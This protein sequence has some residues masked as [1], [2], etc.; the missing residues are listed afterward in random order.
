VS[1]ARNLDDQPERGSSTAVPPRGGK[2]KNGSRPSRPPARGGN[3]RGGSGPRKPGSGGRQARQAAQ[4]RNRMYA[5]VAVGAAVVVI[6]VVVAIGVSGSSSGAP[7]RPATA[8]E[9]QQV[10]SIPVSTLVAGNQKIQPST[11]ATHAAGG[12]LTSNGKPELLFIGAEFCPVCATERWPMTIALMKFGTFNNLQVTSSAKAD[13]DI[14]TWSYYGSTYSSPYL[15]FNPK[16]LYTNQPSGNYYKPLDTLTKAEQANW[17]AN[18]GSNESFPFINFGGQAVLES[19]QFNPATLQ[20]KSFQTILSSVGSNDNT[21][22][23]QINSAAAVFTKY[24]C[25]MTNNQPSNVCSA[26][27]NVNAPI[28]SSNSGTSTP[29]SGG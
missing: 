15:S 16:E 12:A 14:G 9:V 6:A 21:I 25:N 5:L 3:G 4:R 19:S 17:A 11:F 13:G 18:E 20:Y 8:A 7:R 29:A 2:S 24:V 10:N 28:V 22:G 26:V 1:E 27:A 23:A